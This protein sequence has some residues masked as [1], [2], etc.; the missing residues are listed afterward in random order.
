MGTGRHLTA[1][2]RYAEQTAMRAWTA[3]QLR[4]QAGSRRT[5]LAVG[6]MA[7]VLVALAAFFVV[8]APTV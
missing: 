6:A 4:D 7:A 2:D 3:G 8:F 5:T 1:G